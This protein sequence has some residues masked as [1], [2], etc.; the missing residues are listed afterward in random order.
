MTYSFS[1]VTTCLFLDSIS[2][3]ALSNSLWHMHVHTLS[4]AHIH[5][6]IHIRV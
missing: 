6:R 5:I 1:C 4:H 3:V 2:C